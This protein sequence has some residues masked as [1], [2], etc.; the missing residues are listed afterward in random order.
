MNFLLLRR[1]P[2]VA[3]LLT[4]G[5]PSLTRAATITVPSTA[6]PTIQSG[7]NAAQSGDT[8]LVADGTYTG[9][10]NVD[11]DFGGRNITV[12]SV[13]GPTNTIIDC[14]GSAANPHRGVY[15]H[16]GETAAATVNGFT[17]RDGLIP[18]S[19]PGAS[20]SG[21][22]IAIVASS[23]TITN[24]AFI[25]NT[26][27]SGGGIEIF[28]TCSPTIANC[29]FNGNTASAFGGA[30]NNDGATLAVTKC[31]ITNNSA[32]LGGGIMF[33][34]FSKGTVA[35]CTLNSNI[36]SNGGG[37]GIEVFYSS[38]SVTDACFLSNQAYAGG[39]IYN[40][41]N[42]N[43]SLFNCTFEGN[44]A[45]YRYGAGGVGG[46]AGLVIT[47][48]ILW[49][50]G[51]IETPYLATYSD[52]QGGNTGTGNINADPLFVNAA[53]GD[54]HLKPGSPC[55]GAGTP[56]GAPPTDLD[57][58]PRPNPPSVGAY[59][60]FTVPQYQITDLGLLGGLASYG[61][62]I[63]NVGQVVGYISTGTNDFFFSQQRAFVWTNGQVLYFSS[64]PQG[65]GSEATVINNSGLVAGLSNI[66]AGQ[67]PYDAVVWSGGEPPLDL[68][69]LGGSYSY[70]LSMNDK[71]Q[72]AGAS[73]FTNF[74]A[75][76][77]AFV[78]TNGVMTDIDNFGDSLY[79][80]AKG[81]N[82]NGRAVGQHY[83]DGVGVFAFYY[84]G[85]KSRD[86]NDQSV[87][88]D[89]A[90][91]TYLYSADGINDTG[92]ICGSGENTQYNATFEEAF[93]W[94][95]GMIQRLGWPAGDTGSHATAINASGQ[96]I[97]YSHT[98]GGVAH[99]FLYVNRA[100]YDVDSLIADHRGFSGLS[101]SAIN[102]AGAIVGTGTVNNEAHAFILTPFGQGTAVD[103]RELH[104]TSTDSG[105]ARDVDGIVCDNLSGMDDNDTAKDKLALSLPNFLGATNLTGTVAALGPNTNDTGYVKTLNDG[106]TYYIPPDEYNENQVPADVAKDITKSATRTVT[107]TLRFTSNGTQHT[108]I[109]PITLAR[110]PVVLI[111]GIN[112]SPA[113]WTPLTGQDAVITQ[114]GIRIPIVALDHSDVQGGNGPV[115]V[116]ASRLSSLITTVLEDVHNRKPV[117]DD[118]YY[119]FEDYVPY[120][121]A[122][123]RVDVVAWS[124]GGVIARWYIHPA[125]SSLSQTWYKQSTPTLPPVN[126]HGD[127]RKLITLGS[128]WRGVPLAN[129]ANE[130]NF[131]STNGI[132]LGDAPLN[133][134]ALALSALAGFFHVNLGSNVGSLVDFL[135]TKLPLKPEHAP[136]IQVI[137]INSPWMAWL[138][139]GN[140]I[141]GGLAVPFDDNIAYG[142]VAGD[143]NE[144]PIT[145]NGLTLRSDIYTLLDDS[146]T[147]SLPP[148]SWFP[149]L[150]IEHRGKPS[151]GNYSDGIVPVWSSAIPGSYKLAPTTHKE[152]P[153][154]PATQN[155][156]IQSLNS[157]ALPLGSNLNSIWNDPAS[158][159][160]PR[161][162]VRVQDKSWQYIPNQMA[163]LPQSDLYQ[164]INGVGRINPTALREINTATTSSVGATSVVVSWVTA[165]DT[166]SKVKLYLTNQ[167][168][169]NGRPQLPISEAHSDD[170]RKIHQ[171][172]VTGL[173]PNK[174][175]Y[176]FVQSN[177][178]NSPDASFTLSSAPTNLPSFRTASANQPDIFVAVANRNLTGRSFDLRFTNGGGIAQN[179]SVIDLNFSV[180]G[181]G[182]VKPT[183]PPV[184]GSFGPAQ[185]MTVNYTAGPP[186]PTL[187]VRVNYKYQD[188]SGNQITA[189]TSWLRLK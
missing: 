62:G 109:K 56:N 18:D 160:D 46:G 101:L 9:P 124:Y 22:A 183:N 78:Y 144:Y 82:N 68:K 130:V 178:D 186:T 147:A 4:L 173:S 20:N 55:L 189:N 146:T 136:S 110:T 149:Y 7:I 141:P 24:C 133:Q 54:L 40:D 95:Q 174:R 73:G 6:Y 118:L 64:L 23:P 163:P 37:G 63:N 83:R 31:A 53:A 75:E 114:G 100:I 1:L 52:I 76:T 180:Y 48:C 176:Y 67:A 116:A 16:S 187:L 35:G 29:T 27:Y 81:I 148:Y 152:Y 80:V 107:L 169:I 26:A 170:K 184:L 138:L 30:V 126:Y 117:T 84:D 12:R 122:E 145:F 112:S 177:F 115:E 34:N 50:D 77:H 17:V 181:Y 58:T 13:N 164:Q 188:T 39:G 38:V 104:L 42:S 106:K 94:Q 85:S 11:L 5:L 156:V 161:Y 98:T 103:Q 159:S 72:V 129:Y 89:N 2:L 97:G 179:L 86:L 96:V 93:I 139:Y 153:A 125:D 33:N 43:C 88:L 155:Y 59:E 113:S 120:H 121:L 102:D 142:S 168:Y 158:W 165:T 172:L 131:P 71:G 19:Y 135:D 134:E 49:N 60:L 66:S 28:R 185:T 92:Q 87:T 128:M 36:A 14:Q 70:P 3:F 90:G 91:L 99:P 10:G 119:R 166:D 61:L 105:T 32:Q 47:N 8:V 25:G 137:A 74:S 79:S 69:T 162:A 41:S 45:S 132:A 21:G 154:D 143:D 108:V 182:M 171:V 175:Y 127:V 44:T 167:A 111:H 150:G 157:A 151:A 57:G 140:P 51:K 15:F 123:K 65:V